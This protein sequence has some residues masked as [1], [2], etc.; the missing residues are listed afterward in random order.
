MALPGDTRIFVS[1][2]AHLAAIHRNVYITAWWG[3]T[4]VER[5]K[6]VGEIQNE[7]ARKWPAGFVALALIRSSNVNM[8]ADVRAEAEKLSKEPAPNLKAIAQ[9]IY[10]SG[11]AA[12][13][14]RSIATGMVLVARRPRPTK[15]FG[16]LEGA[17]T[18][19]A[20][21]MNELPEPADRIAD[22]ALVKNVRDIVSHAAPKNTAVAPW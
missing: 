6:R 11:F 21:Q 13:A 1:D 19:L 8:P 22:A 7:L 14:I 5:L 9:V 3:E 4:T 2:E 17:A 12:A 15:I 10:G 18:W 20:P 16:T